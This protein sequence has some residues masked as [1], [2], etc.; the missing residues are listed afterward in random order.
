M[1]NNLNSNGMQSNAYAGSPVGIQQGP[2]TAVGG[3]G[4]N[5]GNFNFDWLSG[6]LGKVGGALSGST[7]KYGLAP[8]LMSGILGAGNIWMG[9]KQYGLAKKQLKFGR[10]A[11]NRQ[12]ENQAKTTNAA[13]LGQAEA[14]YAS[15]K[16]AYAEPSAWMDKHAVSG[17][18]V[19]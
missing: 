15:N 9:M 8:T 2:Q 10:E 7:G 16:N 17:R 4:A 1:G 5:A 3:P 18:G 14:R 13:L 11:F 19:G 12:M 6:G